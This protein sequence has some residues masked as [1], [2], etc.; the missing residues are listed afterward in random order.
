MKRIVAGSIFV[1]LIAALAGAQTFRGAV[2]GT[3]TDPSGS[4]V[5]NAPVTAGHV[6]SLPI[7]LG[8]A[9]A[10]TTVEVSAAAIALDTTTPTQTFNISEQAVQDVPLN[11]R[12]FSQLI[13]TSAGY[14]GYSVGGFGSL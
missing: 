12:D 11:G 7:K 8:I 3:V 5:P 9:K 14:G 2:S 1:I 6:Y 4:V 13:G 10:A